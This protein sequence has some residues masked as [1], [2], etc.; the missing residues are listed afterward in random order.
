MIIFPSFVNNRVFPL[1]S[2]TMS[3]PYTC[4]ILKW[5]SARFRRCS[6]SLYTLNPIQPSA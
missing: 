2:T 4:D 1:I 3:K 5:P 6:G